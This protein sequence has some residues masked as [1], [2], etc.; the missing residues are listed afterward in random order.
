[1]ERKKLTPEQLALLA[2]YESN[3]RTAVR[4]DWTRGITSA[5]LS[6]MAAIREA[7]TGVRQ[8]LNR[9]CPFCLLELVR[10]VGRWYFADKPAVAPSPAPVKA[11][12]PR[13]KRAT[14]KKTSPR[15]SAKTK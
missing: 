2:P 15:K 11:A 4:S 5:G 8:S 10:T 3:M 6:T 13:T 7:V 1:M 9:S 12:K 14:T